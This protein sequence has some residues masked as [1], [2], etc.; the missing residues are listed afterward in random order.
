M[1]LG[2]DLRSIKTDIAGVRGGSD[3]GTSGGAAS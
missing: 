2:D 3:T 1:N